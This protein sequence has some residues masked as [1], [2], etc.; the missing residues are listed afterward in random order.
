MQHNI[1]AVLTML[2]F[3]YEKIMYAELNTKSDFCLE[4]GFN[5]EI[6]PF[7]NEEGK[8]GWE[9][10]NCHNTNQEKMSVIRRTCGYLGGNYWNQGRTQEIAERVL[11][12]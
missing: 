12:L 4:C 7:K 9:C 6:K 3:I 11:H 5:G 10:P 8:W 1:P 2:Q